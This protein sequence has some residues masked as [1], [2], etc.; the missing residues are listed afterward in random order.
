MSK[1]IYFR[2]RHNADRIMATLA[3]IAANL[4]YVNAG[5][6]NPG[7]GNVAELLAAIANGEIAVVQLDDA[8]RN[9][10]IPWLV[11][12]AVTP[13]LTET[14]NAIAGAL[15]EARLRKTAT[16]KPL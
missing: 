2:N 6:P 7:A 15:D 1:L 11:T 5:G 3:E 4:G 9:A 13:S 12:R 16:A 14:L 8:Q 10:V